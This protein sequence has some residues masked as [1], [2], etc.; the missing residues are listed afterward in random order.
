M[1]VCEWRDKREGHPTGRDQERQANADRGRE[2][3]SWLNF[4]LFSAW[5]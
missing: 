4:D 3:A 1:C 5:K 2:E